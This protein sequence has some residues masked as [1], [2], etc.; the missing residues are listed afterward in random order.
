MFVYSIEW[1]L[2]QEGGIKLF[3][4]LYFKNLFLL[5]HDL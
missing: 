2:R 3:T 4:H 5:Q 1:L